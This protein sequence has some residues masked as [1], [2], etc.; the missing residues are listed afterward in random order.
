MGIG[1]TVFMRN[2]RHFFTKYKR[3]ITHDIKIKPML[4]LSWRRR[5]DMQISAGGRFDPL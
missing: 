2:L 1:E 5:F 4:T 3:F